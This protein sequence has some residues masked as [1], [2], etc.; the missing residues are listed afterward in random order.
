MLKGCIYQRERQREVGGWSERERERG[1]CSKDASITVTYAGEM[2]DRWSHEGG[3]SMRGV[4]R[5]I[6]VGWMW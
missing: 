3:R 5:C 1:K 4:G 2:Q 6:S